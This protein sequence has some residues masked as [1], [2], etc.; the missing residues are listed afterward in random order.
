MTLPDIQAL[1]SDHDFKLTRVGVTGVQKP[2]QIQRPEGDAVNALHATFDVFVDLP[3]DQKGVHMS[4]NLEA[5][6]ATLDRAVREPQ[7]G[8]EWVV[9]GIARSLLER[10]EYASVAEVEAEATFFIEQR[11]HSG[12]E[13]LEPYTL[14]AQAMADRDGGL[15][16]RI[17]V[18]VTGMTACPCAM[19]N[20]R[21]ILEE[22]ANATIENAPSVTHNQRNNTLLMLDV[23]ESA[24]VDAKD[25]VAI[26]EQSMS[27][28]T[29]ELL[30]RGDEA[31]LVLQAHEHPRF[32]EDVVREALA[33]VVKAYGHLPDDTVI[34]VKSEAEESIH[35]H[36][37]F[38][39]RVTTLAELAE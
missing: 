1:R 15:R 31:R 7:A 13:T 3:A 5:I 6:S 24:D 38:A 39:E 35:K 29:Y 28:P 4:R 14:V 26:V 32:V 23:D 27:A 12:A 16:R 25:L 10:H 2:V 21:H 18:V 22:E 36:N 17:G 19:E 20:T 30:K 8:L 33:R 34:T 9:E 11:T 37:A